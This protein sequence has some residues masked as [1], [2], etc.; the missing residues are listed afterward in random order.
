MNTKMEQT[1]IELEIEKLTRER[2]RNLFAIRPLQFVSGLLLMAI[3]LIFTITQSEAQQFV[4]ERYYKFENP[5]VGHDDMGNGDMD[6][7]R[8]NSGYTVNSNGPVNKYLSMD[9]TGALISAGMFEPQQYMTVEFLIRPGLDFIGK[10][11]MH[12]RDGAFEIGFDLPSYTSFYPKLRFI[13]KHIDGG[14]NT[15]TDGWTIDL[16]GIG[17][18]SIGHYADGEFHHLVFIFN[19]VTGKKQIWVDGQL[20]PDFERSI[21]TGA[22]GNLGQPPELWFNY[23]I[24][25]RKFHGDLDE[26]AFY[27]QALSPS[28]VYKHYLEFQQ[29]QHYS[30]NDD[31]TG[32]I[33]TAPPTSAPID[34]MEFPPGHPNV[35]ISAV[36]QIKSFPTPRYKND[37]TLLENFPWFDGLRV[38]GLQ[39]GVSTNTQIRH[40]LI[41]LTKELCERWNYSLQ[42]SGNTRAHYE[43]D[44]TTKVSGAMVKLANANPQWKTSAITFWAQT[45]PADI[46]YNTSF[47]HILL[48]TLPN[49]YYL[50]N[51]SGQFHW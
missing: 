37:H 36:D 29:G 2:S 41:R 16:D 34:M 19:G 44:D 5:N 39:D 28:M 40:Q 48:N 51:A 7:Q 38:A 1:P 18:K 22:M 24:A 6:F 10:N 9:Q 4:P 12:R 31:Y 47:P 8:W 49:N 33:P 46:G 23:S 35:T 42:V 11:I 26:M 32:T 14:G 20:H 45:K 25:S 15:V 3:L 21:A 43:Y 50:R 17:L 27:D 30:W 13:T